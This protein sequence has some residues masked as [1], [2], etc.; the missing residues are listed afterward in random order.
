MYRTWADEAVQYQIATPPNVQIT[1]KAPQMPRVLIDQDDMYDGIFV[2]L[3][4]END[5]QKL[6]W[7]LLSYIT[8]LTEY[9]IA[10]QHNLNE[11]MITTLVTS[12]KAI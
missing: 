11:L 5:L 3:D 1:T 2:K 10:V 9:G 7:V 6:E 12:L 8:S 4:N